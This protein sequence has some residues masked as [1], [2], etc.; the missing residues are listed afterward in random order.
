MQ[1]GKA[2]RKASL[3]STAGSI[4]TLQAAAQGTGWLE[5]PL[6]RLMD[7]FVLS[8]HTSPCAASWATS[9]LGVKPGMISFRISLLDAELLGSILAGQRKELQ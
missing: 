2:N 6:C 1:K 8:A 4:R 5:K 7:G 9:Q 3:T